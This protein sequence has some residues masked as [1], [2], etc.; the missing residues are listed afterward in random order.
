MEE[1]PDAW[2]SGQ[3]RAWEKEIPEMLDPEIAEAVA[4]E[5]KELGFEFVTLDLI[6]RDL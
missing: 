6:G 3:D 5:I 4:Y 2:Q 1:S